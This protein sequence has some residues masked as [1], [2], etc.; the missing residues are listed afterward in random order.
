MTKLTHSFNL[1]FI[2]ICFG[3]CCSTAFLSCAQK[4]KDK[5]ESPLGYDLSAPEKYNMP[6]ALLEIS[7]FA[8]ANGDPSKVY[9]QQDEEGK[10]FTI[11]LGSKK[12][13]HTKFAKDGDF[14]DIAI[15][16]GKVMVLKS[17]G[18][19]FSF[20]LEETK[21]KETKNV[22]HT[23]SV[24][25]KGEYEGMYADVIQ[26]KLYVICKECAVDKGTKQTSGFILSLQTEGL[27]KLSG[28]FK[29]DVSTVSKLS[30][31]KKGTF[32]PSALAKHP[33]TSE[34]Y[35][36]SAINKTLVVTDNQWK[37][38]NL[39]PLSVN[40]FNQPEGIAFDHNANL[41]I[42]NEGSDTQYGNILK[43]SYK[44]QKK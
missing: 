15:A 41:Y 13:Q 3:L 35:L 40:E 2:G 5:V 24:L 14:E 43:F 1:T 18:D 22:A 21:N 29:I 9:A 36:L 11:S 42:S 19:L 33:L 10:V 27:F 8:F 30:G 6:E 44:A 23:K 16:W 4:K 17:N 32:H 34:W 38:K 31:R 37:I 12:Y 39:Y 20:A 7:G 26:N 28:T 25:P